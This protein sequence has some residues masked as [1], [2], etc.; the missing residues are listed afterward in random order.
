MH[1]RGSV[2]IADATVELRRIMCCSLSDNAD[3]MI[4]LQFYRVSCPLVSCCGVVIFF[5]LTPC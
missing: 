3:T 5:S 1:L 4:P 2:R